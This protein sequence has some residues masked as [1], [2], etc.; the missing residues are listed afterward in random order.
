M[1]HHGVTRHV[2]GH[3]ETQVRLWAWDKPRAFCAWGSNIVISCDIM[4]L[5]DVTSGFSF[6]LKKQL[7]IVGLHNGCWGKIPSC[8]CECLSSRCSSCF[9]TWNCPSHCWELLSE[10]RSDCSTW[11]L[12]VMADWFYPSCHRASA[13][14][15][16]ASWLKKWQECMHRCPPPSGAW[17]SALSC[18]TLDM[19]LGRAYRERCF[20]QS[21][22]TSMRPLFR[23]YSLV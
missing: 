15:S 9:Q 21:P 5:Y 18:H 13:C 12:P 3:I 19:P 2:G 6:W 20:P 7:E 10:L 23:L 22:W 11:A 1:G 8:H 16:I 4:M 17:A 14:T